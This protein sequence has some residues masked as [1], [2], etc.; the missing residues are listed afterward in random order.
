MSFTENTELYQPLCIFHDLA[1]GKVPDQREKYR[2]RKVFLVKSQVKSNF[3]MPEPKI[4]R[5]HRVLPVYDKNWDSTYR[6][7]PQSYS[8]KWNLSGTLICFIK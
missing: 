1:T 8:Q 4:V 7:P 6:S 5:L 3:T 2:A